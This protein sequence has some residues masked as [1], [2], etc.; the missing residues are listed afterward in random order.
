[1]SCDSVERVKGVATAS[2]RRSGKPSGQKKNIKKAR[3]HK[4]DTVQI[5][6]D[7]FIVSGTRP[8]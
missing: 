4:S 5:G 1:M 8:Y 2:A 7:A 3:T 6:Y